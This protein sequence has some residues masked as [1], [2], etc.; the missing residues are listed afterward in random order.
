MGRPNG[1]RY[2]GR[3]EETRM[4]SNGRWRRV[5]GITP[6]YG[7]QRER[8]WTP[9]QAKAQ[10]TR[11]SFNS[12]ETHLVRKWEDIGHLRALSPWINGWMLW[13][14]HSSKL[15]PAIELFS[16]SLPLFSS[17]WKPMCSTLVSL[18]V[19]LYKFANYLIAIEESSFWGMQRSSFV[20]QACDR[21]PF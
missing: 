16:L 3:K 6:R 2:V 21:A 13:K 15:N 1:C 11:A 9:T 20:Y 14:L 5:D 18:E 17:P 7:R 10:D 12:L 8:R 19:T 4:K